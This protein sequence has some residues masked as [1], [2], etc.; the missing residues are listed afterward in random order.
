MKVMVNELAAS[1]LNVNSIGSFTVIYKRLVYV[2]FML[3]LQE[4]VNFRLKCPVKCKV[5]ACEDAVGSDYIIDVRFYGQAFHFMFQ[6]VP[7]IELL[8]LKMRMCGV[9]QSQYLGMFTLLEH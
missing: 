7:H 9:T 3:K 2:K 5:F 8:A 1:Y 4:N 6:P